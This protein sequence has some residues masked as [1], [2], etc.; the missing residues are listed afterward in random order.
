MDRSPEAFDLHVLSPPLAFALSQ[1]QT[2]Q[3]NILLLY[4]SYSNENYYLCFKD[5]QDAFRLTFLDKGTSSSPQAHA[6]YRPTIGASSESD[7][8]N[9][10]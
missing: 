7:A 3:F 5:R 9:K 1:D 6:Y 8:F 2:L 4:F 10:N